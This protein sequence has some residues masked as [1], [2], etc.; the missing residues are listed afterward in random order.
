[1]QIV[2]SV[3]CSCH[4]SCALRAEPCRSFRCQIII[5]FCTRSWGRTSVLRLEV[6]RGCV[7]RGNYY[8]STGCKH[9]TSGY[10][11]VACR[12]YFRARIATCVSAMKMMPRSAGSGTKFFCETI[13]SG[14]FHQ[15]FWA[16]PELL[17]SKKD[18]H[19][20]LVCIVCFVPSANGFE[21]ALQYRGYKA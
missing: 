8:A 6:L 4:I 20:I 5:E 11:R 21:T 2:P 12:V 14:E 13:I 1:M 15:K 3:L 19:P 7:Y 17:R 16:S 18:K 10:I 9:F